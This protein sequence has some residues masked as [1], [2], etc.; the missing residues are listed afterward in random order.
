MK[1]EILVSINR[2]ELL[3]TN[4]EPFRHLIMS[5]GRIKFTD[6]YIEYSDLIASYDFVNTVLFY[7]FCTV[8]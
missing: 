3:G 8:L 6:K 5:S 1:T 2:N 4:E 7:V